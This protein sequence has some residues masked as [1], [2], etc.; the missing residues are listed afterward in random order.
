MV[1]RVI[2]LNSIRYSGYLGGAIL[3]SILLIGFIPFTHFFLSK[4]LRQTPLTG[5]RSIEIEE[6]SEKKKKKNI[7]KSLFKT[8]SRNPLNFNSRVPSLRFAMDLSV[9]GSGEDAAA[10]SADHL[11]TEGYEIGQVDTPPVERRA[12]ILNFP[13]RA[14]EEQLEGRVLLRCLISEEGRVLKLI[15][16]KEEPAGYGFAQAAMNGL[17]ESEFIPAKLKGIPVKCWAI[18][19]IE[20]SLN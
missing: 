18:K 1:N 9:G 13:L 14:Q 5:Q 10:V 6:F 19:E 3:I 4:P 2:F 11:K 7:Q 12:L 20:F 15:L 17:K 16:L 8:L